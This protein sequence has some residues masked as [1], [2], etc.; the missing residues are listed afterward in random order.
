MGTLSGDGYYQDLDEDRWGGYDAD[1]LQR[2]L[3]RQDDMNAMSDRFEANGRAEVGATIE[4]AC[5]GR[6]VVKRSYQ[7]KFC[8]PTQKGKKKSYRCKDRYNNIV[9]P[10]GKF[11]HLA[12]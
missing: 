2:D 9:N 7:Q 5:C 6:K 1:S 12:D 4:C 10:R 11:A 8:P 3:E